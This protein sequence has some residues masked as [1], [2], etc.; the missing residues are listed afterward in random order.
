[1]QIYKNNIYTTWHYLNYLLYGIGFTK[2][3]VLQY[4]PAYLFSV[5]IEKKKAIIKLFHGVF[6]NQQNMQEPHDF[7]LSLE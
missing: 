3:Q 2:R 4:T 7:P 5:L 6:N 1:M